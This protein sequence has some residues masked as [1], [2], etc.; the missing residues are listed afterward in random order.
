MKT[1][2]HTPQ[3]LIRLAAFVAILIGSMTLIHAQSLP[4]P[5]YHW[6]FTDGDGGANSGTALISPLTI[7]N[8]TSGTVAFSDTGLNLTGNIGA[9]NTPQAQAGYAMGALGSIG[10]LSQFTLTFWIYTPVAKSGYQSILTIGPSNG[11]MTGADDVLFI[12]YN[13]SVGSNNNKLEVWVGGS[14]VT[15]I[16]TQQSESTPV[17]NGEWHFIAISYDGTST[18]VDNSIVQQNATGT[19]TNRGTSNLQIYQGSADF[20]DNLARQG[21][22]W[23]L[24]GTNWQTNKGALE[25]G[26]DSSIFLGSRTDFSRTLSGMLKDVRIYDE[27]LSV[28]Q[29]NDIRTIPEPQSMALILMAAL[30]SVALYR[31]RRR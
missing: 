8:N 9:Q 14:D 21:F 18:R 19:T 15:G 2:S 17:L 22:N 24:G 10:T 5:V 28:S 20:D 12:R 25:L 26:D 4:D 7:T 13:S 1:T 16:T 31:T 27:V 29:I 3:H 11:D 30:S 6:T 23:G